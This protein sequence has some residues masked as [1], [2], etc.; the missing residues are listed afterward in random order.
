[1]IDSQ[2]LLSLLTPGKK[3]SGVPLFIF[4]P[5][6]DGT[7]LL[8]STQ[9]QGL[10]NHVD[11]RCVVLPSGPG[12]VWE[13]LTEQVIQTIRHEKRMTGHPEVYLCGESFG[14]CLAL[15]VALHAPDLIDHLIL[16]NPATAFQRRIWASWSASA[17]RLL[18]EMAYALSC[19]MLLPFLAN[20]DQV[21][22]Q[23]AQAL[24][25]AMRSVGYPAALNRIHL[26]KQFDL[27]DEQY[28]QIIQP[29]LIVASDRD[30]LLPSVD[31]GHWLASLIPNACVHRLPNSGHAC[32]LERDVSLLEIMR[33]SEFG[34]VGSQAHTASLPSA[35]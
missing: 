1:M 27:T 14:G 6:M 17:L 5:G 23:E 21:D 15:L 26:L 19:N 29:T 11:I 24:L 3:K 7:G 10:R 20:L 2:P 25:G 4:L 16:V 31:E 33:A 9:E 35:S 12:K 34:T 30:R 22:M 28:R 8:F 13:T 18:P 32:L